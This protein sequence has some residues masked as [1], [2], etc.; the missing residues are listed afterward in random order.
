MEAVKGR[1]TFYQLTIDDTYTISG[2]ETPEE[3]NAKKT[4]VLD[5]FENSL[6]KKYKKNLNGIYTYMNLVAQGVS[7]PK[8]K[9]KEI[10]PDKETV[11]EY[12]FKNGDL[13]VYAI[14]TSA[15]KIILFPGYKNKQKK[16]INQFRELKRQYLLS[17][18]K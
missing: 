14:K 17:L 2:N 5:F 1:E 8:E 16:E 15:G 18:K 12:E 10:T 9:F 7:V 3:L 6:E 13:R 11:K 4:G